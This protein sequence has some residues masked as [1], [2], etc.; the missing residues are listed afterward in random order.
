MC[1]DKWQRQ[2]AIVVETVLLFSKQMTNVSINTSA[3]F[4]SGP[5]AISTSS[6]TQGDAL[7]YVAH[8]YH[9]R[10]EVLECSLYKISNGICTVRMSCKTLP[11]KYFN[12]VHERLQSAMCEQD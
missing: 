12:H 6:Y 11:C 7:V 2:A 5:F 10:D 3:S 9:S 8:C 4:G 1:S